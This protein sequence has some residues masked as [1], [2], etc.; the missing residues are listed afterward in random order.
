MAPRRDALIFQLRPQAALQQAAAAAS[1]QPAPQVLAEAA[2]PVAVPTPAR[3][4]QQTSRYY[5]VHREAGH[6]PD[7]TP[8]PEAVFYDSVALDLAEPPETEPPLR[9]AQGRLR[10]PVRDED[11]ERP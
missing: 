10:P 11:P 6:A 5:S 9:D 4:G 1:D 2:P 8:L 7:R 3:P